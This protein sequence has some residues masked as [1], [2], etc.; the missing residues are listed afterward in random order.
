MEADFQIAAMQ[1]TGEVQVSFTNDSDQLVL[2]CELVTKFE[3]DNFVR[4]LLGN[5][6]YNTLVQMENVLAASGAAFNLIER[7]K[8]DM[9]CPY[10]LTV[11][12][13]PLSRSIFE[14]V[15]GLGSGTQLLRRQLYYLIMK[16]GNDYCSPI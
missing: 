4:R 2:G 11:T 1:R 16:C 9:R 14:D 10:L 5:V 3:I 12:Y 6:N 7:A 13:N 8:D 15:L